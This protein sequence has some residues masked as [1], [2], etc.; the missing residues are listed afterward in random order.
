MLSIEKGK[1]IKIQGFKHDKTLHRTWDSVMVLECNED[2]IVVASKSNRVTE[3]DGRIWYTKEPAVS[4]FFFKEWFNVIA[5]IRGK[6]IYYYCNIASPSLIDHGIIKYIDYDLDLKLLPN[7]HIMGLDEKEYEFHRKKY[8]YSFNL[9]IVC[10]HS[11]LKVALMMEDKA[12]PFIDAK[13]SEYYQLFE[14]L[15]H[16]QDIV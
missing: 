3:S 6:E 9:D 13:I 16:H 15:R 7:G 11:Y 2:F 5:M 4:I 14:K 1:W 10:R 8:G 12:F